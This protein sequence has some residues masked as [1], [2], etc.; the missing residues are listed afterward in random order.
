MELI[1]HEAK[2][3][4][5]KLLGDLGYTYAIFFRV[6]FPNA[7][8][9]VLVRPL[10]ICTKELIKVNTTE[11]LADLEPLCADFTLQKSE[12][13]SYKNSGV[14]ILHDI[15]PNHN[16]KFNWYFQKDYTYF[17]DEAFKNYLD[18]DPNLVKFTVKDENLKKITVP[19]KFQQIAHLGYNNFIGVEIFVEGLSIIWAIKKLGSYNFI[20]DKYNITKG[21]IKQISIWSFVH[22]STFENIAKD[23]YYRPLE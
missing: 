7:L 6:Q 8:E 17:P 1:L 14:K 16:N 19:Y 18:P 2:F 15:H 10:N 12:I 9:F 3:A 22:L 11:V 23:N 5:I 21:S 4:S 13:R 20:T